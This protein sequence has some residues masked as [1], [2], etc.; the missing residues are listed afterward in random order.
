MADN[1]VV[2]GSRI[3]QPGLAAPQGFEAKTAQRASAPDRAYPAFLSRLQAAVRSGDR[4]T[5]SGLIAFP[6]RVN[7]AGRPHLYR[8]A[9]SV[10]RD[11]DRIFTP[12]VR[13]AVLAQR[14]DRLFVRDQGATVGNGEI[15]FDRTCS[16]PT[17]SPLGPV[18][19][20]AVNP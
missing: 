15:W 5:V 9:R 16:N 19:I 8:N 12:R 20:T 1:V 6:L 13:Q 17:C 2:T 10:E 4:R 3:Q 11:F 7:T 18:R 14:G